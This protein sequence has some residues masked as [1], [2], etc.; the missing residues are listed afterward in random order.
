MHDHQILRDDSTNADDTPE[1]DTENLA[2]ERGGVDQGLVIGRDELRGEEGCHGGVL[3]CWKMLVDDRRSEGDEF[4]LYLPTISIR[5]S[6]SHA[7]TQTLA[8]ILLGGRKVRF[9]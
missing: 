4:Q 3:V 2:L 5:I 7:A 9:C 8:K 1:V 6:T